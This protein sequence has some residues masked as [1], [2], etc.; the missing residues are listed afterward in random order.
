[1]NPEP[2]LSSPCSNG[3][4]NNRADDVEVEHHADDLDRTFG[5]IHSTPEA[6]KKQMLEIAG[7]Q[8]QREVDEDWL[9]QMRFLTCGT[10]YLNYVYDIIASELR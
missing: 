7:H 2:E 5:E 8:L 9:R 1:M 6:L 4:R 3:D 10:S